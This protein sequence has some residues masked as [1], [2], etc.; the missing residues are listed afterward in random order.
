M[1]QPSLFL[2][3]ILAVLIFPGAA[4]LAAQQ[5]PEAEKL[6]QDSMKRFTVR[7]PAH[8]SAAENADGTSLTIAGEEAMLVIS[9]LYR[10]NSVEE[11][12]RRLALSFAVNALS[13]PPKKAKVKWEKRRIGNLKA[14][15]SIYD[16]RGGLKD[17][18]EKYRVH[19]ITV[20]GEKHKFSLVCTIPLEFVER[21]QLEERLRKVEGS[22]V[23]LE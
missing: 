9:P 23:E 21:N 10:G 19:V 15:E 20:D 8:W 6:V 1:K 17:I 11:M 14:L 3:L 7:M 2:R 12:Q 13:G 18:H 16:I 22:L 4:F 5:P